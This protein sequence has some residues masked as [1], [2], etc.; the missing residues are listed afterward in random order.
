VCAE[1]GEIAAGTYKLP[2]FNKDKKFT[3]FKSLGKQF[4]FNKTNVSIVRTNNTITNKYAGSSFYCT[5]QLLIT[6][7]AAR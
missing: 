4:L 3:V 2:A 5:M 6:A 7:L 1:L